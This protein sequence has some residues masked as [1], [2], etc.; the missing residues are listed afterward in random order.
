MIIEFG[1]WQ[2]RPV[3]ASNWQLW[4]H[5]AMTAGKDKGTAKWAPCG[6]FYSYSTL[7]NALLYAA[8]CDIK[9]TDG[10]ANFVEYVELL[11]ETLDGFEKSIL[12]ALESSQSRANE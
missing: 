10:T 12:R 4:H 5:H 7:D 11:R 6:K 2:L 8:D 1:D 9:A 3:D